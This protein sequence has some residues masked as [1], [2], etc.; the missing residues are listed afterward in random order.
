MPKWAIWN[1]DDPYGQGNPYCQYGQNMYMR[2]QNGP[3]KIR[4][5]PYWVLGEPYEGQIWLYG[6]KE[7]LW[8]P[9][10]GPFRTNGFIGHPFWAQENHVGLKNSLLSLKVSK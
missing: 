6:A 5:D 4:R 9:V 10:L 7:G 1:L 3:V 8:R 2:E